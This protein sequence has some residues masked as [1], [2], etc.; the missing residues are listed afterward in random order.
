MPAHE[1]RSWLIDMDGVIVREEEPIEGSAAVLAGLRARGMPF[2]V[3]TN[4]SIYTPSDLAARLRMSG[5]DVSEDDIWTSALA[6]ARFLDDQR[7]GGSAFTIGEAGLTTALYEV[8][9]VQTEYNPDY[10]VLGETRTYSFERITKAIR[11]HE[12]RRHPGGAADQRGHRSRRREGP[13]GARPGG[14]GVGGDEPGPGV[15]QPDGPGDCLGAVGTGL[16]QHDIAGS[17]S[18]ST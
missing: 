10:V 15:D 14:V 17:R 6:T 5:V 11:L 12:V 1:P 8:G 9:Y 2:L 16:P 13:G 4:N 18:L 7:P 3:L